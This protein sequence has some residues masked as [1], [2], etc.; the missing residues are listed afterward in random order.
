MKGGLNIELKSL[1]VDE[2]FFYPAI[3]AR[4]EL[5][6]DL[7]QEAP[8]NLFG[9]LTF[10]GKLI[11]RMESK[12]TLSQEF[13]I[14]PTDYNRNYGYKNL[15]IDLTCTLDKKIVSHMNDA[16]RIS[17]KGDVDILIEL[18]LTYLRN[19]A[20]ISYIMEYPLDD[21]TFPKDFK[22]AIE[23]QWPVSYKNISVLL[24][25]YQTQT[26]SYSQNKTNLN[27]I[28]STGLGPNSGYLTIKTEKITLETTIKSSD[29]IH[30]FLPK[31]G[32]GEYEIIEIP[33]VKETNDLSVILQRLDDAKDKLY[34]DLDIGASL[35]SL[36]N[37]IR[38]FKE[39]VKGKGEFEKLFD[40][41]NNLKVLTKTLQENLYGAA[42]RSE[43]S[44]SAH[45]GGAK[46]E[47]YETESMIF[48][49]YALYKMVFDRIKSK[50]N[51]G[52]E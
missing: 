46:V 44:T 31:L 24:Y 20:L 49:T 13:K 11:G 14:G 42:S 47:G 29:W 45:A 39:F 51:R 38:E 7:N 8:I 25:A 19:E 1:S 17:V 30:D 43:D 50:D 36:R 9:T 27:L 10:Q 23:K 21:S 35:A 26:G 28:S 37:S 18:S 5:K 4:F 41:N 22:A 48:M 12:V 2:S 33:K 6:Y 34:K 40:D 15:E 3:K 32:I 52:G 16:R